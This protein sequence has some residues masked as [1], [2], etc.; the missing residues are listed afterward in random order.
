MGSLLQNEK[1]KIMGSISNEKNGGKNGGDKHVKKGKVGGDWW[2]NCIIFFSLR[3]SSEA[4]AI[5]P[6]LKEITP[7]TNFYLQ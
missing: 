7:V 4:D 3:A 6:P 5:A 2:C 1:C